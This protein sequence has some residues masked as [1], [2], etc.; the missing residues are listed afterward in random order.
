MRSCP[1]HVTLRD[2]IIRRGMSQTAA[3]DL[4]R[5][6][7]SHLSHLVLARRRPSL[8]LAVRIERAMGIPAASWG[9]G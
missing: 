1:P 4:L 3:A 7:R 9:A 8:A 6:S 2:T 5:V